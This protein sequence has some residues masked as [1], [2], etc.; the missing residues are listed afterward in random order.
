MINR[1]MYVVA[2]ERLQERPAVAILGPRQVGKTTLA[3]QLVEGYG[4][5]SIRLDL[6]DPDARATLADPMKY[7]SAHADKLVVIDEIQR[8][9]ELFQALRVLIDRDRRPGRFLLLGSSS[10]VIVKR[11]AESL[12]GRVSYLD[13]Y[14]LSVTETGPER[15]PDLWL[16]GGFPDAFLA[17][18]DAAAFRVVGDLLRSVTERDLPQLGLAADPKNTNTLL[19]MLA[20][21]HAQPL[22]MSMLAKSIGL[23]VPTIKQ[24]LQFFEQAYLVFPLQSFHF[25]SWKRLTKA[26]KM[27]ITDSGMLHALTGVRTR[28]DLARNLLVG[29]SWEGFVIQQIR[30]WL[31]RRAELYYYRTQD[32]SELDLV[33]TQGLQPKV[34]IEIKTTNSPALSKG[35]HLAFDAVN[36]PVRLIL[37]PDAMDHSYGKGI[38]VCS[39]ATVWKHLEKALA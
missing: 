26:P 3:G 31:D 15:M 11:A 20:S 13:L 14:P 34:A 2:L 21:V 1:E 29:H 24:Y 28:E 18:S 23:S 4:G 12:A 33:I 5:H 19:H 37:T 27:Y 36:A 35:N 22:N 7:L 30:A 9:P 6:E 8:M 39:L 32:G 17:G 16:R 38:E 10:P 25:N